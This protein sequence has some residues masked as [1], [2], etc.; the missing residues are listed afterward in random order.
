MFPAD[1]ARNHPDALGLFGVVTAWS[2]SLITQRQHGTL[3]FPI[4]ESAL[5]QAE[6]CAP[7]CPQ[8]Q[9]LSEYP[10]PPSVLTSRYFHV[11]ELVAEPALRSDLILQ[12]RQRNSLKRVTDGA[13]VAAT[14]GE[15]PFRMG[16]VPQPQRR[17]SSQSDPSPPSPPCPPGLV[18]VQDEKEKGQVQLMVYFKS[19]SS[20]FLC[21][22]TPL[23]SRNI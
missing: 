4:W 12:T 23:P 11:Q 21:R 9:S 6:H 18:T 22:N 19:D 3:R 5:C 20:R 2:V 13:M 17:P 10:P 15:A 1:G 16:W 14:C 8:P 7:S